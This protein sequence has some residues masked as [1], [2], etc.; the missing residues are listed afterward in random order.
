MNLTFRERVKQGFS[1]S[2]LAPLPETREFFVRMVDFVDEDGCHSKTPVS[3]KPDLV[4]GYLFSVDPLLKSGN[5]DLL[6]PTPGIQ[7]TLFQ[8]ADAIPDDFILTPEML[9]PSDPV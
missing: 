2:S 1:R 7:P 9:H 5:T 6:R 3:F 4:D 8:S